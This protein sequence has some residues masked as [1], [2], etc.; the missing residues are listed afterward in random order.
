MKIL[1][2]PKDIAYIPGNIIKCSC[3]AVFEYSESDLREIHSWRR[4][5][6]FLGFNCQFCGIELIARDGEI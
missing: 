4:E 5:K 6:P 1:K 2:Y 3:K